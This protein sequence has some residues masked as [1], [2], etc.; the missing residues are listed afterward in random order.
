MLTDTAASKQLLELSHQLVNAAD[1]ELWDDVSL[2]QQRVHELLQASDALQVYARNTLEQVLAAIN[3]AMDMTV[4]RR[5][6]I[7]A[8]VKILSK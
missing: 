6:E 4:R 5:D 3:T 1:K 7:H 2:L 8:L